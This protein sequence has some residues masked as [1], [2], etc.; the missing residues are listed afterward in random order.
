MKAHLETIL[1]ESAE[2]RERRQ[3][4]ADRYKQMEVVAA[5]ESAEYFEVLATLPSN[6]AEKASY[7][8][9]TELLRSH[10][11]DTEKWLE[12][13]PTERRTDFEQALRWMKDRGSGISKESTGERGNRPKD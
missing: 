2:V 11:H 8:Q 9:A 10:N 7:M 3:A 5:R 4:N 13:L 1:K 12:F 6:S